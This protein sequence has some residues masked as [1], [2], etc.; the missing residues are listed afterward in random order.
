VT[1]LITLNHFLRT[2][3]IFFIIF[4]SLTK[5]A[6]KVSLTFD[7]RDE[8]KRKVIAENLAKLID[9]S[10]DIS[11]TVI[12]G[13]WGT[14]KTEFSLKLLD[15]ISTAYP[16]KKVIYIDAFKEDH[17]E[18]PLQ[19]RLQARYHSPNKRLLYKKPFLLLSLLVQQP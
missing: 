6:I 2:A 4:L 7:D 1:T 10:V 8:Y 16:D 18:D 15:Y 5:G 12:D 17:C 13:N 14:G 19:L 11:P 9:S 3:L